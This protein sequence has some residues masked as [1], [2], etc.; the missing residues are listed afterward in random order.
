MDC[1]QAQT[2]LS[3][4]LD[5]EILPEDRPQLAAHLSECA[6]CRASLEA[7]QVLNADLRRAFAP[8][9]QAATPVADRVVSPLAPLPAPNGRARRRRLPWL[10]MLLSAAAGFL[11]AVLVFRPWDKPQ[12]QPS[13]PDAGET[14]QPD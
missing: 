11:V 10:P 14:T 6:V 2:L 9:R 1:E 7:S 4:Q 8:R 13:T 5:R 12:V 3:A